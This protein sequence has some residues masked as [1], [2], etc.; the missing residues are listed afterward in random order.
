MEKLV[1]LIYGVVSRITGYL[2]G[3]PQFATDMD[4]CPKPEAPELVPDG[5]GQLPAATPAEAALDARCDI[6]LA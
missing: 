2:T 5:P 4:W 6:M 1:Y 3:K